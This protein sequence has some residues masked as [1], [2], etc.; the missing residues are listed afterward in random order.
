MFK[1]HLHIWALSL[2]VLFSPSLVFGETA[3]Q[4]GSGEAVFSKSPI[5]PSDPGKS[6]TSFKTGDHIYALLRAG[7]S[8]KEIS[9]KEGNFDVFVQFFVDGEKITGNNITLKSATVATEDYLV[10]DIAP[11]PSKMTAYSN[12]DIQFATFGE[13]KFGPQKFTE[14]LG[15][16]TAGKHTVKVEVSYYGDAYSSGTFEID[17]SD[18]KFYA[19]LNSEI[20]ENIAQNRTLPPAGRTDKALEAKMLELAENAGW[21]N[22][23]TLY[24]KDK[25]WWVEQGVGRHMAA[26]IAA[27]ADDGS[28]FYS[29][30]TFKQNQTLTGWGPLRLDHTGTKIPILKK[31]LG[32]S[33]SGG[34]S[35]GSPFI[36]FRL[37]LA[38]A[39][40]AAGIILLAK[41]L[42][43]YQDKIGG[44][45]QPLLNIKA[46]M[47]VITLALGAVF[48]V[49]N[50]LVLSPLADFLP[51]AVAVVAGLYL[52]L[53]L[54]LKKP[55]VPAAASEEV[56]QPQVSEA[57]AA[58]TEQAGKAEQS[59]AQMAKKVSESATA[60]VEKAQDLL[61]GKRSKIELL[62]AYEVP[63]GAAAVVLGILHLIAGGVPLF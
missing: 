14:I 20:K 30:V 25:D 22:I 34:T 7:K 1:S 51:Q 15:G 63:L 12:P 56:A 17:G 50:I 24:I 3:A 60:G 2:A 49:K 39:L 47:G 61:A 16:L 13:E 27:Q 9:K 42:E 41:V 57:A 8:W 38:L 36:L 45:L 29:V 28:Y 43:K 4:G 58:D 54:L 26:I 37:A 11:K 55:A 31:N 62:K 33:G 19:D 5:D 18:Y 59:S 21:K 23:E 44:I 10:L 32:G 52:G 53:D 6:I 46:L 35:T 48:F 40:I